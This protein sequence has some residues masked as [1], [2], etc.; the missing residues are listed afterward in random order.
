MCSTEAWFPLLP[1]HFFTFIC[2]ELCLLFGCIAAAK[3]SQAGWGRKD[4]QRSP[5]PT[6]LLKQSHPDLVFQDHVQTGFETSQRPWLHDLPGQPTLVLSHPHSEK[7]FT[8]VQETTGGE[9][10]MFRPV[11]V[12]SFFVPWVP[13]RKVWLCLP[14]TLPS[15]IYR[16]RWDP[17]QASSSPGRTVPALPACPHRKGASV[18]YRPRGPPLDSL[19]CVQVSLV[20][21]GP[22]P[23]LQVRPH[24][25]WAEGEDRL[26]WPAGNTLPNATQD[27]LSCFCSKGTLLFRVQVGVHQET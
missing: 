5:G 27:T 4:L 12:A 24:R 19:Q 26:S 21:G 10:P 15:C 25:S 11:S 18:P 9:H 20:L 8:D 22:G 1:L 16:H 7:V 2:F 14:S 23:A 13:V 17:L 3:E 6:P